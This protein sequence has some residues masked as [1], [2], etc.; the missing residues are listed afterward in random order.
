M[1]SAIRER[2]APGR[3]FR[4]IALSAVAGLA[5]IWLIPPG[6]TAQAEEAKRLKLRLRP[7]ASSKGID[8][9]RGFCLQCHG[10]E[11]KGNG[12]LAKGLRTPPADLTRI[13]QRNGGKFPRVAVGRFI[14]GDRPGSTT[15]LDEDW[16]PTVYRKGV[17]DD[18]PFWRYHFGSLYPDDSVNPIRFESLAAYVESIQAK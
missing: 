6:S 12:P 7:V 1:S 13:A 17:A 4:A 9:Y 15:R 14:M 5:L 16:N 8:L 3:A 2:S 10:P 18:M 11:G